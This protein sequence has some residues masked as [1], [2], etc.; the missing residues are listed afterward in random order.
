MSFCSAIRFSITLGMFRLDFCFSDGR[1]SVVERT[2]NTNVTTAIIRPD[3]RMAT[4]AMAGQAET[5]NANY[6]DEAAA[7]QLA[8]LWSIDPTTL[9]EQFQ[10]P[11]MGLVGQFPGT[12]SGTN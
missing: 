3:D 5:K 12:E 6:P 2:P 4:P 11:E 10:E 1:S 7:M 9:D 8:A